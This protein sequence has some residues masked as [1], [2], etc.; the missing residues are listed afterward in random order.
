MA[1][2]VEHGTSNGTAVQP[3]NQSIHP[4]QST[5]E[6]TWITIAYLPL[7]VAIIAGNALI[8]GAF[9]YERRLRT[10]TTT[11][12]IG[13]S[14]ADLLVGLILV[15]CWLVIQAG[16][17]TTSFYHFYITTDI[18]IGCSSVLQLASISIE[19]Y[20]AIL[21]PI[22]HR[23]LNRK[24]FYIALA[25]AWLYAATIAILEP[26][27]FRKWERVYTTLV[28]VTCFLFPLIIISVAY[29]KIYWAA[30]SANKN[31]YLNCNRST[32]KKECRLSATVALL[33]I[34]IVITWLP[35]F[36]LS[37]VATFDPQLL[38][39]QA[40]TTRLVNFFKWMHYSNS[41][42]NS[43]LYSYRNPGLKRT[44]YKMLCKLLGKGDLT[45]GESVT[46][47]WF[48]RR[49]SSRSIASA[50]RKTS[51]ISNQDKNSPRRKISEI[52][53][54]GDNNNNAPPFVIQL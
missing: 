24:V 33:P 18:F 29:V 42:L 3:T 52:S 16:H 38:P 54:K 7:M 47:V 5:T 4:L 36:S 32:F 46:S 11:L 22:K 49:N 37:M 6:M 17:H 25:A 40:M 39:G 43:F 50:S 13:L 31:K 30:K 9:A 26:V 2:L 1:R 19:R 48:R 53:V 41:C 15:P 10:T 34:M 45:R 27:Q 12:I 51:T 23:L 14:V 8:I 20:H 35:L 44:I 21:H 28:T